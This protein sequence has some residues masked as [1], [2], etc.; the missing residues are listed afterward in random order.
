MAPPALRTPRL[1][2]GLLAQGGLAVAMAVN[3]T[4]V[5][6]DLN[7]RL[8]LSAALLSVLLFEIVASREGASLVEGLEP[9]SAA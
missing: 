5:R 8:I 9:R 6:P 2:R 4:Q 7:P 3:Y 1:A